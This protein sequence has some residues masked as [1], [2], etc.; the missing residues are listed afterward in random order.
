MT[1]YDP[2]I[3]F[4]A[5][6]PL[7][8]RVI[9]LVGL[10]ILGWATNLHGLDALGVD[11]AAAFDLRPRAP[12]PSN[13][14][15]LVPPPQALHT[16]IYR[17]FVAYA[18]WCMLAW[19]LFRYA[20]YSNTLLV[21]VFRYIPAL[22]ALSI[23][24]VLVSPFNVCFK[25]E[26]DMFLHAIRRCI[27]PPTNRP[28]YFS[29][30]VFADVFTSFAKILGDVWLSF[31]MLLPG[32]SLLESP[33][34]DGWTRWILPTIV[35]LPYLVRLRQCLVE[36]TATSN[37]SRRPLFN[38]L[39]YATSFPVIFLSAAQRIVVNDLV[40]EKGAAA[41]GE[42]W[43]GEHPLFRMWLLAA[44]INSLY[45]FW[46]DVTNDW[47]LD[48]LKPPPPAA[49]PPPRQL[50]LPTL[51][52]SS[53]SHS[54][55]LSSESLLNRHSRTPS[56]IQYPY[57]LR[58]TLLY[59]L[60]TYPL[61]IFLNLILR[62]TWSLKLSSHLHTGMHEGSV[63]MLALEVAEVLRRWMWVFVRVEWEVVRRRERGYGHA[64]VEPRHD[65]SDDEEYELVGT[66]A[67][68]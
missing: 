28:I 62:L 26:R 39:K 48:L 66:D 55:S 15:K 65:E 67:R 10:G 58:S 14:F 45:S 18:G 13:G 12:L 17:V 59:P 6:F 64:F 41:A 31:N 49:A 61:L 43:H 44:L 60:P 57:G 54:S 25:R 27:L 47:G 42:A 24:T 22:C 16:P 2:E 34:L 37:T 20:T 5:A 63:V 29:D 68:A 9:F 30:V 51:H 4:A 36:H 19:T 3:A 23:V 33:A 50:V 46:W 21:D 53:S 35:S 38:A 11:A 8:F 40:E 56:H 52:S 1:D 32:N 7:P